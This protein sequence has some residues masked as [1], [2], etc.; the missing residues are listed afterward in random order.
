MKVSNELATALIGYKDRLCE[1]Y[2]Q[3]CPTT[4]DRYNVEFE[5]GSKYVKVV[6][7]SWGS[8]S[9]HSFVEK[10]SGSIWRA[11]SWKSPARNFVRGNIFD[12]SSYINRVSWT[13]IV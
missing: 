12:M 4:T 10:K 5:I 9:V 8:R 2:F 11:A 7:V 13:G 3:R 6:L 1:N